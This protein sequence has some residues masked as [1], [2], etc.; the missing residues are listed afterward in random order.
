MQSCCVSD[1][2]HSSA[3][4]HHSVATKWY[5]AK[6]GE[7][8]LTLNGF[9]KVKALCVLLL[10]PN[11]LCHKG[12]INGLWKR[13]GYREC[14]IHQ[15]T[16]DS[17]WVKAGS[18]SCDSLPPQWPCVCEC[19]CVY[20]RG[21]QRNTNKLERSVCE[22]VR[23]CPRVTMCLSCNSVFVCAYVHVCPAGTFELTT[24]HET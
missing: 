19:V 23:N 22:C 16:W 10:P 15:A 7:T 13:T 21:M 2:V 4:W 9:N 11:S 24:G 3:D 8:C 5:S 6:E 14:L 17:G 12:E 1:T 20:V 18:I